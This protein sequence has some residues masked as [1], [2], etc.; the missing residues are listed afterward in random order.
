MPWKDTGV[1]EDPAFGSC[2]TRCGDFFAIIY[3]TN[4]FTHSFKFGQQEIGHV[5]EIFHQK[6]QKTIARGFNLDI[7]AKQDRKKVRKQAQIEEKWT[8]PRKNQPEDPENKSR[9]FQFGYYGKAG[10]EKSPEIP[11]GIP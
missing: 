9:R 10:Q 11:E 1:G 6:T 5:Q 4:E 7:M 8:Y 2:G 3:D